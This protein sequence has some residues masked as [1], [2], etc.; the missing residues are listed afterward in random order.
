MI[1]GAYTDKLPFQTVRHMHLWLLALT[2]VCTPF[3]W[4]EAKYDP[5][6]RDQLV[7][8]PDFVIYA[9]LGV[10]TITDGPIEL[11]D[12]V[13]AA[14]SSAD[15]NLLYD[16]DDADL[17]GQRVDLRSLVISIEN[18]KCTSVAICPYEQ[19]L[20]YQDLKSDLIE[21]FALGKTAKQIIEHFELPGWS[22]E[23]QNAFWLQ[24]GPSNSVQIEMKDGNCIHVS[25][26][27][28]WH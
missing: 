3:N 11:S 20:K 21:E 13:W 27:A 23:S 7:G 28:A 25:R 24:T 8:M 15:T 22:S 1:I 4:H 19:I 10:P 16:R 18:H 12:A 14:A 26:W 17:M 6:I 5:N 2:L 9:R